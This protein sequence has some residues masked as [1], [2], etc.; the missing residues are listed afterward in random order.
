VETDED[1]AVLPGETLAK[2]GASESE[3]V[4]GFAAERAEEAPFVEASEAEGPVPA[5]EFEEPIEQEPADAPRAADRIPEDF[6]EVPIPLAMEEVSQPD[7]PP[8]Q[9]EPVPSASAEQEFENP[10][11]ESDSHEP[12]AE[13]AGAQAE[14]AEPARIP[15]SL[16]ATLREQGPRF[17][18]RMS[19]RMRRKMRAGGPAPAPADRPAETT[20]E[21]QAPEVR[22]EA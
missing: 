18:H 16:T 2:Y 10:P 9:D 20:R 8:Y 17:L 21:V 14:G 19:R 7:V 4:A 12:A 22:S 13:A 6:P 5:I 11:A 1:F 3:E 15:T